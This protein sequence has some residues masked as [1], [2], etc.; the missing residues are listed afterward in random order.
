MKTTTKF[1][2]LVCASFV[3]AGCQQDAPIVETQAGPGEIEITASNGEADATRTVLNGLQTE[4]LA[5]DQIGVFSPEAGASNSVLMAQ[6]AGKTSNF[7]GSFAWS[8]TAATHSFYA[9]YPYQ[10]GTFPATAVPV[11]VPNYQQQESG[12]S[13]KHLAQL[14]KLVATPVTG[15]NTGSAVAMEFAHAFSVLEIRIKG[16]GLV[17]GVRVHTGAYDSMLAFDG[18]TIDITQPKPAAGVPYTIKGVDYEDGTEVTGKRYNFVELYLSEPVVLTDDATTTPALYM[19]VNPQNLAGKPLVF[20]IWGRNGVMALTTSNFNIERGKKYQFVLNYTI[21][22]EENVLDYIEDEEFRNYLQQMYGNDIVSSEQAARVE[23]LDL[24]HIGIKDLSGI[25]YFTGLREFRCA[26]SALTRADF[27]KNLN[28]QSLNLELN[29]NLAEL[30]LGEN[31]NL[32]QLIVNFTKV[33]SLNLAAHPNLNLFYGFECPISEIDLSKN[34]N[35]YALDMRNCQ[36]TAIDV[37]QNTALDNL[38]IGGNKLTAIDLSKNKALQLLD[39]AGNQIK[40]LN[41]LQNTN[42]VRLDFS[43]NPLMVTSSTGNHVAMI[44]TSRSLEYLDCSNTGLT[45]IVISSPLLT[46]LHA[47]GNEISTLS[48]SSNVNLEY[49]YLGGNNLS[50][51]NGVG[52]LSKLSVID[53]SHNLFTSFDISQNTQLELFGCEGNPGDSNGQFRIKSL[54]DDATKVPAEFPTKAWVYE[55]AD[56]TSN[57]VTPVYYFEGTTPGTGGTEDL[58]DGGTT[59]LRRR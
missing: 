31:Q 21:K 53:I 17:D 39:I 49:V 28:L 48:L 52:K 22:A 11:F 50:V 57:S 37:T 10:S 38:M 44:L 42:L 35:L 8:S 47:Q 2:A 3:L 41:V 12:N 6:T 56:G 34:T 1:A 43:R 13:T 20:E 16:A 7:R 33:D 36:L 26:E 51:L 19:V 40:A 32:S 5:N 29:K 59:E 46:E 18:A 23:H 24:S 25:E 4:W 55:T 9:Y 45:D 15:L 58:G 27:S 54:F 14:D 30:H